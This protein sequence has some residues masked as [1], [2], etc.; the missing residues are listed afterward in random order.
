[1]AHETL[2]TID[3]L[4]RFDDLSGAALHSAEVRRIG[5]IPRAEQPAYV[6]AAQQGDIEARNELVINC[7]N[8]TM[9]KAASIYQDKQPEHSD[10]MDLVGHA[11]VSMLESMPR[12]LRARDPVRYL[13]A[14]SEVEMR[15]YCLYHDPMVKRPN[16]RAPT[17]PHPTT[18]SLEAESYTVVGRAVQLEAEQPALGYQLISDALASLSATRRAIMEAAYGLNGFPAMRIGEIALRFNLPKK[19]VENYLYRSK[20]QLARKM[21]EQ[22]ET[23]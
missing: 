11:H 10:L 3:E 15:I 12:A 19:T 16:W 17:Y 2:P 4:N 6:A 20:R 14:V 9:T 5:F 13:M 23:Y 7:L 1:M 21:A 18:V 22:L 8:W